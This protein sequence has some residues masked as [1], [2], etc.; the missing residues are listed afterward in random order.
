MCQLCAVIVTSNRVFRVD[1][2]RHHSELWDLLK[3]EYPD[4]V[5][6]GVEAEFDLLKRQWGYGKEKAVLATVGSERARLLYQFAQ[7]NFADADGLIRFV[8]HAGAPCRDN[9]DATLCLTV[10]AEADYKA[11]CALL[12][13]DY[14]A[15]RA[16]LDK[17][18]HAKRAPLDK[19]YHAKRA[20]LD[21]DYHAKCAPLDKDYHAKCATLDKD[22]HAKRAP[23][24]KDYH[25]KCADPWI[26]LF[27]N[28]ENRIPIWRD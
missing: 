8:E 22:Y 6:A 18:Y 9:G 7:E 20:P 17:D 28:P 13:K 15:K 27:A 4:E 2:V 24:D 16:P 19:D 10:A 21:K 11:K 1:G 3:A 12:Y 23:L 5:G 26:N 25:A 14:N